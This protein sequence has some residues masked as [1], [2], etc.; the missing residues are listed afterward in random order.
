MSKICSMCGQP[1][2]DDAFY[3]CKNGIR[4]GRLD[5]RCKECTRVAS[6]TWR[7]AHPGHSAA[8]QHAVGKCAPMEKTKD[9][10]LYLGVV[11]AERALSGFFDH[12]KRMPFGNP[13]YDFIC[14]KG[15]KID[16]KASCLNIRQNKTPIWTF[17]IRKNKTADYFLCLAFNDRK[18][19]TPMH[20]WLIPGN[21][22][23]SRRGIGITNSRRPLSKWAIHERSLEKVNECCNRMEMQQP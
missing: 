2:Q 19:L 5:S 11:V 12:I 3:M 6:R 7:N 18:S 22:I 10:A 14:G 4:A 13:G 20:V 1:K 21:A 8:Y 17:D 16:V 23:N 15:Y 9:C